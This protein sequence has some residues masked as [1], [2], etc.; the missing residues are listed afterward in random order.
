MTKLVFNP[1][2]PTEWSMC[3]LG[4]KNIFSE[5]VYLEMVK[6]NKITVRIFEHTKTA[7]S[8]TFQI[9]EVS[10][11]VNIEI[12]GFKF[13]TKTEFNY[14]SHKQNTNSYFK[15]LKSQGL[16]EYLNYL[17]AIF[18]KIYP[19]FPN[20]TINVDIQGLRKY[21]TDFDEVIEKFNNR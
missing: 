1:I 19:N 20:E 16:N 6:E 18:N 21:F 7:L 12:E 11:G 17:E 14:F 3:I 13:K 4:S 2:F 10:N 5:S 9:G 15:V 8:T